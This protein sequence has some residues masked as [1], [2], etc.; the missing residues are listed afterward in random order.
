MKRNIKAFL[1]TL[2]FMVVN[3]IVFY[4]FIHLFNDV[5]TAS[6][7][8]W[9]AVAV[10]TLFTIVYLEMRDLIKNNEKDKS[11]SPE[12]GGVEKSKSISE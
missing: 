6:V 8:T 3:L 11:K 12:N 7:A 9:F 2:L 5:I 1:Y 4:G 10:P